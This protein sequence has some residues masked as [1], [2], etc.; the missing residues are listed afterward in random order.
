MVGTIKIDR[1]NLP[2]NERP[3]RGACPDAAQHKLPVGR[4]YA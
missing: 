3:A 4:N 1:C 2:V